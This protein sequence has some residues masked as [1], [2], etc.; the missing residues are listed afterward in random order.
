MHPLPKYANEPHPKL[1]GSGILIALNPKD[2]KLPSRPSGAWLASALRKAGIDKP[3]V[4][5]VPPRHDVP[6]LY[7]SFEWQG[8]RFT[9]EGRQSFKSLVEGLVLGEHL[10]LSYLWNSSLGYNHYEFYLFTEKKV[11]GHE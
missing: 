10:F 3:E 7:G 11:A 4:T 9:F 8:D 5:Y 2:L 6:C 1:G